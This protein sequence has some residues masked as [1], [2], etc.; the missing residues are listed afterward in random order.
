MDTEA[1]FGA[2]RPTGAVATMLALTQK[3]ILGR[4]QTRKAIGNMLRQRTRTPIDVQL[5]GRNARLH[6]QSNH[7]EMKAVLNPRN[8]SH[9]DF[10]FIR[11]QL[12]RAG[13]FLDIGANAGM[14]SLFASSLL[15]AGGCV[16][17][18]EPQPGLFARLLYNMTV[19]NDLA[20]EGVR[21]VL[22]QTAVGPENGTAELAVPN[23][24]GQASLSPHVGGARMSVP[25]IPLGDLLR[26]EGV[27]RVDVMKIDVEGYEDEVLQSFFEK[28]DRSL[29]A[30]AVLIEHCNSTRWKWDCIAHMKSIGYVQAHR[31]SAN[32]FLT[33]QDARS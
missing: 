17:A 33:L 20:S 4:G 13:T 12:P 15:G 16:V 9:R 18:V 19:A 2:Y 28:E 10:A 1:P 27:T 5:W 3:T 32:V 29:F 24:L 30:R 7:A 23:E 14:F 25:L 21:T 8:Y 26:R 11:Q 6:L 31:D 22:A